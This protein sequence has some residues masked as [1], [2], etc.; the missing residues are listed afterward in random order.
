MNYLAHAFL[1]RQDD[2]LVLGGLLGDHVR[3]LRA[4]LGYPFR[5]RQG[6]RLHRFID[7]TTDANPQV[8]ELLRIFPRPFRRYAGIIVDL[9]FDHELAR[10]WSRYSDQSLE[11]F[12]AH[13]RSLLG[14]H[15]KLVP[16]ALERFMAYADRRGLFAAYREESELMHSLAGVG[17]RLRRANPLG[18]VSSIWPEV[19][20]PCAET[21]EAVFPTIQSD[22]E[23]W[24]RRRSTTT[25]S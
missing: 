11:S 22:V 9:A 16:P 23:A 15:E 12:D 2:D 25:G 24:I 4:L 10:H 3:G 13:L 18:E 5:I 14:D 6:I 19:R 7:R 8:R 17:R 20:R 1:P 21:F